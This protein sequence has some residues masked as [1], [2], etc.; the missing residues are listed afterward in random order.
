MK[1]G[2]AYMGF[3]VS[4]LGSMLTVLPRYHGIQGT[5]NDLIDGYVEFEAVK[6][7]SPI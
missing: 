7:S 3:L 1:I 6:R 4:D 2:P 5:V